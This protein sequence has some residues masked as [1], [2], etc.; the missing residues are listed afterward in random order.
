[1]AHS[2]LVVST[3]VGSVPAAFQD[4]AELILA[5]VGDVD[6][7]TAAVERLIG[8]D[9]LRRRMLR[10]AFARSA[11]VSVEAVSSAILSAAIERWPVLESL[12]GDP[13]APAAPG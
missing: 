13:S 2:V 5:D 10:A 9:E 7:A 1:M 12:D 11:E 4:G 6:A 8:D 3:P